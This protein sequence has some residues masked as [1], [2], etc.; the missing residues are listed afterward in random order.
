M[1][2]RMVGRNRLYCKQL[3]I[4][5]KNSETSSVP[6]WQCFTVSLHAIRYRTQIPDQQQV[7][8]EV[9]FGTAN[10]RLDVLSQQPEPRATLAYAEKTLI[11][12]KDSLTLS[13]QQRQQQH[14]VVFLPHPIFP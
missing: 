14:Q 2:Y 11:T 7:G 10:L 1:I 8:G 12:Y 3:G 4:F 5:S 9:I 6:N 13:P